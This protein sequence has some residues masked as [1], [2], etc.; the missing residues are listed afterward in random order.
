[1]AVEMERMAS[2]IKIVD[3][4]LHDLVLLQHKRVGIVAVHLGDV[5]I[6]ARRQGRVETWHLG[7]R[8][9]DVVEESAAENVSQ[10]Q[11]EGRVSIDRY[12]T[13]LHQF[14]GCP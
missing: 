7:G 1:M 3:D 2:R 10:V 13:S 12:R 14:P 4:N 6:I 9:S 5:G 8:V 11:G